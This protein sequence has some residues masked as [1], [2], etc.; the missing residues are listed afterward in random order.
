MDKL[1]LLDEARIKPTDSH[2]QVVRDD[3]YLKPYEDDIQL[4]MDKFK[5]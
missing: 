3:P 5:E 2:I 4:R 1:L